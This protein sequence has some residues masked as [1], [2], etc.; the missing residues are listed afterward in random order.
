MANKTQKHWKELTWFAARNCWKKY[1]DGKVRYYK[2]TGEETHESYDEALREYLYDKKK[3]GAMS[4]PAGVAPCGY[5]SPGGLSIAAAIARYV[6]EYEA[7][8]KAN[9]KSL[10]RFDKVKQYMGYFTKF[11]GSEKCCGLSERLL[12]NYRAVL[13]TKLAQQ[14]LG[15]WTVKYALQEVC[16]FTKW[17]WRQR[18]I[19]DLPRNLLDLSVG[20]KRKP[21]AAFSKEDVQALW[22]SADEDNQKL[23]LALALNT[24][25]T[26]ADIAALKASNYAEG[27]LFKSREKTGIQGAWKVWNETARLIDQCRSDKNPEDLLFT[28]R[29]GQPLLHT[30]TNKKGKRVKTDSIAQTF[31]RLARKAGVKGSFARLRKTAAC[32]VESEGY[33]D[34]V[35]L[36]LAHSRRSVAE[37]YY[38]TEEARRKALMKNGRL[39]EA[40]LAVQ[41]YFGI[42][43]TT[44]VAPLPED[45]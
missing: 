38:L 41:T 27:F 44:G 35:Q 17:A 24:G 37:T 12:S 5:S 2:G 4:A 28:T 30:T 26:Q 29:Q 8:Y 3:Q 14:K 39:I 19:A 11:V 43:Q 42:G 10:G 21:V 20:I 25:M 32:A 9:Q 16:S 45:A 22:A 6:R 7:D 13:L 36:F 40:I 15:Q 1:F 31:A 34:C 33:S 18:L 23:Y